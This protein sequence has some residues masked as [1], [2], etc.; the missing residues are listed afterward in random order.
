MAAAAAAACTAQAPKRLASGSILPAP[1][2]RLR[3]GTAP[4]PARPRARPSAGAPRRRRA[5]RIVM[6]LMMTFPRSCGGDMSTPQKY[7]PTRHYLQTT[8]DNRRAVDSA[9]DPQSPDGL[10]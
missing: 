5:R 9:G 2:H 7:P 10:G 3:P 6:T 4:R 8:S 1:G